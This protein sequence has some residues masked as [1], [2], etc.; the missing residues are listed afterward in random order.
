[1]IT[2]TAV[3]FLGGGGGETDTFGDAFFDDIDGVTNALDNVAARSF[4]FFWSREWERQ[5]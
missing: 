3:F 4:L 2:D 5:C 1:M